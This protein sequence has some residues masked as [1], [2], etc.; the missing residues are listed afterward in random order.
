MRALR[1]VA[2]AVHVPD[3]AAEELRDRAADRHVCG[4]RKAHERRHRTHVRDGLHVRALGVRAKELVLVQR[5]PLAGDRG[6]VHPL[7]RHDH[8]EALVQRAV[9]KPLARKGRHDQAGHEHGARLLRGEQQV[10]VPRRAGEERRVLAERRLRH[11]RHEPV[12]EERAR[13]LE[14]H[15]QRAVVGR[16]A[17]SLELSL[18]AGPRAARRAGDAQR[19][20]AQLGHRGAPVV[21][22][23]EDAAD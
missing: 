5:V 4:V 8:A 15:D 14:H 19:R 6:D 9:V 23:V 13:L 20:G 2:A 10:G 21:D 12:Q 7:V 3:A 18:H 22:R 17:R 11:R 16:E 1:A